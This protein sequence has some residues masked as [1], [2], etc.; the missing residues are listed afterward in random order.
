MRAWLAI[1]DKQRNRL[2]Q[3]HLSAAVRLKVQSWFS[4]SDFP[5][6]EALKH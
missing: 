6:V 2:K 1:K 5:Y 4:I 3:P